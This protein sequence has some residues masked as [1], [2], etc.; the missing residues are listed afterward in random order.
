MRLKTKISFLVVALF[1]LTLF[2]CCSNQRVVTTACDYGYP[3]PVATQVPPPEYMYEGPIE[4]WDNP[5]EWTWYRVDAA[6]GM[7]GGEPPGGDEVQPL[8]A[9]TPSTASGGGGDH[10]NS[11][12]YVPTNLTS[13][14]GTPEPPPWYAEFRES[15]A[16][17][18]EGAVQFP[19]ERTMKQGVSEIVKVKVFPDAI[20]A[21]TNDEEAGE[22]IEPLKVSIVMCAQLLGDPKVFGIQQI[23]EEC[24]VTV[25]PYTEWAWEVDP[26]LSGE[27]KLRLALVNKV[28]AE[29]R[30]ELRNELAKTAIIDVQVNIPF[31]I[32]KLWRDYW[33][34]FIASLG[35]LGGVWAWVK[36]L[37]KK[38]RQ[39]A[40]F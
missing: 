11:Y 15:Y 12:S 19:S 13:S 27:H 33:Q 2:W 20:M 30:E 17:L 28:W 25:V 21:N 6:G 9:P 31:I 26:K 32:E 10:A 40:G 38:K 14:D 18:K 3:L 16:K 4:G 5:E 23:G 1:T 34:W 22:T 35:G 7:P 24:Q 37:R 36:N 29:E 39:Q 8:S